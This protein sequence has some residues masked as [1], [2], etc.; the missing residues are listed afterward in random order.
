MSNA[1]TNGHAVGSTLHFPPR[2]THL[3]AIPKADPD[4]EKMAIIGHHFARIMEALGLDLTDPSLHET[5]Q[6][7][8]KMFVK[9]VFSG[10]DE[11]NFPKIT[12]FPNDYGYGEMLV[13]KNISLHTFCEHHF[14]P[15]IG[16]VHVAYF[17][18]E[19][20]VGLSK[21][22]RLVKHYARRPQV[23]ERLTM[24]IAEGLQHVLGTEDVAVYIEADHLCVAARGV[25]DTKSATVTSH[26]GGR[27]KEP[28]E[29]RGFL[30][31]VK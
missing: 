11:R 29:R 24:Q 9:E 5:P 21:L 17:P 31:A 12:T 18:G 13:E 3:H 16:K 23:Q 30:E 1:H 6:R 25:E 26:F 10:L 22:N 2:E 4:V 28:E 14:L 7:V 15:I 8:A 20:V 27:F 19:K